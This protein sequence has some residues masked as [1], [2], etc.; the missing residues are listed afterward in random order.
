MKFKK[1]VAVVSRITNSCVEQVVIVI[2]S[3]VSVKCEQWHK[4]REKI[5]NLTEIEH[6]FVFTWFAINELICKRF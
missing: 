5:N 4:N 3:V 1:T 2:I 6:I